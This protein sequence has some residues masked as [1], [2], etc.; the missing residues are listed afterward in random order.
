MKL[1]K[2]QRAVLDQ[3][4]K[5]PFYGFPAG[6]NYWPLTT[7]DRRGANVDGEVVDELLRAGL[8]VA[9]P[10]PET[11]AGQRSRNTEIAPHLDFNHSINITPAARALLNEGT[12]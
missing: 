3:A 10:L 4:A 8:L 2:A 9:K 5:K 12:R 6:S 7:F 1:T 11:V